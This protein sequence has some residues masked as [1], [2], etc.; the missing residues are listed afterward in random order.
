[1]LSFYQTNML[2]YIWRAGCVDQDI[3]AAAHFF[4]N[5]M[6]IVSVVKSTHKSL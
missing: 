2:S 1:M 3:C 5:V 6:H 4:I